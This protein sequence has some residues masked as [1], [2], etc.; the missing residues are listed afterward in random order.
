MKTPPVFQSF[1]DATKAAFAH[2]QSDYG[3]RLTERRAVGSEAW[4]TYENP[5]T[6]VTV[7]YELGAEPWVEIG[8][9]DLRDGRLVQPASIGLSVW[10]F[11]FADAGNLLTMN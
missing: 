7:H 5:T 3:F 10:N 9:L 1:V 4:G 6:R 2:L 8:R 11:S